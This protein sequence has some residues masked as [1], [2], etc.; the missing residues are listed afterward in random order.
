MAQ[1]PPPRCAHTGN[2]LR[3]ASSLPYLIFYG[4]WDGDRTVFSDAVI[5]DIVHDAWNTSTGRCSF[6]V[7]SMQATTLKLT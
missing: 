6:M 5:Y 1:P 7:V 2:L 3:T 4:G